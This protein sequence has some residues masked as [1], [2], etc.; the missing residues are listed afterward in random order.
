[1]FRLRRDHRS[2]RGAVAVLVAA[3]LAGGVIMGM[4]ALSVDVGAL[5]LERRQLQN[6]ADA[7][8]LSLAT[9]CAKGLPSCDDRPA[10]LLALESLAGLNAGVDGQ[11]QLLKSR[12]DA[13]DGV[14][15]RGVVTLPAC[16][17]ASTNAAITQ[18][19]ECP[20][21][22][23]W[24]TGAGAATPYVETY[25]LTKAADGSSILPKIFSQ[26]LVGGGPNASVSA[27]ARAAWGPP[28]PY[29]A[30]IPIVISACEWKRQTNNGLDYVTPGPTGPRP[31]YGPGLSPW[32]APAK[33]VVVI[34]HDPQDELS[35]CDWNGKDTAGGFGF[36][37]SSS[38][39]AVV[40]PDSWVQIDT[41]NDIPQDCRD[42]LTGLVGT[43]ISMPVF[44]CLVAA[45]DAPTGPIPTTPDGVCDPTQQLSNGNN[46]WYHIAGWA[47]FYV[48]GY[49]LSG[50][51][52]NS[53]LPGGHTSCGTPG[54]RCIYGWF[55]KGVL[56]D[57]TSISPPGGTDFGTYVV[58]P[59]G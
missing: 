46:S 27:C 6:G 40:S 5:M 56:D 7:T 33:E 37:D 51:T 50:A 49:S 58:L 52:V 34:L 15:G 21:I 4:L 29:S 13:P 9:A 12:L 36:V 24:L 11:A 44:D 22:P 8:S 25:T 20:A 39:R 23:T 1:M 3:L 16:A 2:E 28:G 41:G 38:C 45:R 53:I 14:C 35:D 10:D 42:I 18:L 30:T 57:A 26:T 59:A 19:S 47:K 17:S 31:G 32:P 43:T 55:L 48:S 54:A